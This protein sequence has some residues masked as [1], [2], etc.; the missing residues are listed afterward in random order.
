[1][2]FLAGFPAFDPLGHG[3]IR[4]AAAKKAVPL[5]GDRDRSEMGD[6][7]RTIVATS[8]NLA[9]FHSGFSSIVFPAVL[10]PAAGF[11]RITWRTAR[12]RKTRKLLPRGYRNLRS[13]KQRRLPP[14]KTAPPA[15]NR[16][17]VERKRLLDLLQ[18]SACRRL[19]LLKRLPD[20]ARP[21]S[22]SIG[23]NCS[24]ALDRSSRGLASTTMTT[25]Q[26]RSPITLPK[27]FI[28][29]RLRS[30]NRRLIS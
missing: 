30:L 19:V 6:K 17:R 21:L 27:P 14:I 3:A 9:F 18:A 13:P 1:M 28:G 12:S 8:E 20:M 29:Q 22:R 24:G 7:K 4:R 25:S 23:A 2:I 15:A 11:G 5:M 16:L 26:A 10:L